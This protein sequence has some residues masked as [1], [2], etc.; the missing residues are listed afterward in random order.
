MTSITIDVPSSN[1]KEYKQIFNTFVMSY[2]IEE[3]KQ[4]ENI[5]IDLKE[6]D[7]NDLSD[8]NKKA[9]ENSFKVSEADLINI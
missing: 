8:E 5:Q 2:S 7:L 9:Y 6:H 4:I 1:V 3:L